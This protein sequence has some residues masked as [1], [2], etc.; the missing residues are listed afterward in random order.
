MPVSSNQIAEATRCDPT[1]SRV[2]LYTKQGWPTHIE[3]VLRPYSDRRNEQTVDQNCLLWGIRVIVPAKYTEQVLQELHQS[4]PGIV[5]MKAVARS[6][7][8][9]PCINQDIEDLVKECD[10]CQATESAP[11]LAPLHP[12]LWP[13]QPWERIHLDFAGPMRGKMLLVVIDALSKWPEVFP[14]VSTTAQATICVL[15]SL[16]TTYRLPRQVVSDS[17]P[18]FASDEFRLFLENN[19]VKHIKSSPYHPATTGAAE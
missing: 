12:W 10:K 8:W 4:H 2:L 17:C 15:R 1:L 7:V 14:M 6:Y 9:W 3:P 18:Q 5:W 13:T 16:F 19:R 11:P